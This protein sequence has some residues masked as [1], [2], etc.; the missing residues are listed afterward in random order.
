MC[1][2]SKT[3]LVSSIEGNA[4]LLFRNKSPLSN[5][6]VQ[7]SLNIYDHICKTSHEGFTA[8]QINFRSVVTNLCLSKLTQQNIYMELY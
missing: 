8:F 1:I 2:G 5:V 4:I 3:F 7:H 6:T